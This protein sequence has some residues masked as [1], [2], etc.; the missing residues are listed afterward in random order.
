MPVIDNWL[1][2]YI[3]VKLN[4][5]FFILNDTVIYIV[6][7]WLSLFP[8]DCY[9]MKDNNKRLQQTLIFKS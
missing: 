1:D 4:Y 5:L 7:Q 2:E 3:N 6:K 9:Y 8:N